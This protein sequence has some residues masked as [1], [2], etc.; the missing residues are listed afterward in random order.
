MKLGS[1]SF[2]IGK[3]DERQTTYFGSLFTDKFRNDR[4]DISLNIKGKDGKWKRATDLRFEDGTVISIKEVFPKLWLDQGYQIVG[5]GLE[6]T[7]E[8][9]APFAPGDEVPF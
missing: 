2:I 8:D 5:P 7:S 1:I 9:E 4:Y 6:E 3:G